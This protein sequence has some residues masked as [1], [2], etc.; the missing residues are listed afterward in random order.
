M[1]YMYLFGII[2]QAYPHKQHQS[3]VIGGLCSS[4][5]PSHSKLVKICFLCAMDVR[6]RRESKSIELAER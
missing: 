5:R 3:T 4:L 1:S 2:I 6:S